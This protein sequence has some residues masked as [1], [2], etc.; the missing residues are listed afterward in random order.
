MPE[1]HFHNYFI[2]KRIGYRW[3]ASFLEK[4]K[5]LNKIQFIEEWTQKKGKT[6][7]T[8]L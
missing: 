3:D 8:F 7:A 1:Y 6:Q 5:I 2:F 4:F